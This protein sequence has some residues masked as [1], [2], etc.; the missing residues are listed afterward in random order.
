MSLIALACYDTIE[1]KRTPLTKKTLWSLYE[2]VDFHKHRIIIVNNASNDDT[3]QI[4]DNFVYR[5]N[6][7]YFEG[8]ATAIHLPN[9][10][11]TA[12]AINLAWARRKEGEHC[13][14]IDNDVVIHSKGWIEELE[15]AIRREPKI[16]IIGLKRKDLIECTTHEDSNWRSVLLSSYVS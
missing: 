1:N 4:I 15:E 3:K 12:K 7:L 5:V 8:Q 16:G 6:E 10:I 13:I 14:K 9:N 11:G 2:T